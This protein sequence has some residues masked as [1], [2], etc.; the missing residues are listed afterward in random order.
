MFGQSGSSRSRVALAGALGVGL[1]LSLAACGGDKKDD[2]SGSTD[3]ASAGIDCAQFS[4]FGD[5]KGKTV[6][7][8]TGIVTPE[9][10]PHKKSYEAFEKCTGVTVKYEGDKSF[11]TQI[12]VRAKAGNPPDIAYVP[13]PGLL[14]QLVD[15]GKAV[16]APKE[17]SDNTDK[18]FGKDWKSYGTVNGKFYAA[19]LGAN[20]KSLVW[21]S[22]KEFKDKGYTIPT[23][24]DELKQLSD[25]IAATGSKP[26]CAGI[27]SGDATGWPVTDWV[28]DFML[29]VNGVD[30]YDKW[31]SHEIPFNGPESTAAWNAVGDYLKNDKFVNGGIG[32]VKS[33]AATSFQDGGLNILEGTCSLH[34]QASFYAANFPKATKIAE[35]G[36]IYAFYLPGKDASSKPVLGGG[37][38][39]VAFADRPEVKAFQYYL[40]T[41]IWA[42]Q[43]AKASSGWVSANKGLNIENLTNPIDVLSAKILQDPNAQFRFDGSDMM[44]AAVGSNAFWKQ[45]TAWITGQDTA[46]TVNNI[47]AAWP[48]K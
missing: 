7:V 26:W 19:P 36:D 17:V 41:E 25:K 31:V 34:R 47:E 2:S 11:E 10:T 28:E 18:W 3:A 40:S 22:P 9:D 21:Y 20:V 29:R 32:D 5:L 8:Y 46:T 45:A 42:N 15:T 14:K 13:Q 35:D 23:T 43:K 12:L 6:S 39:V 30:A 37:E 4:Q 24:L 27:G 44:P 33:I 1:V 38:F 48:K 16:E